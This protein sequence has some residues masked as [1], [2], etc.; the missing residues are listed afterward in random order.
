MEVFD[1]QRGGDVVVLKVGKP[2]VS[3]AAVR[4]PPP[5]VHRGPRA[6]S[7]CAPEPRMSL[8]VPQEAELLEN[9][10]ARDPGGNVKI[11][12]CLEVGTYRIGHGAPASD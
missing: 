4:A 9:L 12:R 11:V 6:R 7:P 5:P 3:V 10:A 2:G 8:D 1:R